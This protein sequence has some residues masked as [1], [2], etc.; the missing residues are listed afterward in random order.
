MQPILWTVLLGLAAGRS[1]TLPRS[2]SNASCRAIPGDASWPSLDKWYALNETVHGRL[3]AT[4]PLPRVCHSEP[5]GNYNA[6]VC[7]ALKTTWLDDTTFLDHPAEV[8]NPYVQNYTCVPFTPASQPCIL[9]NY[10]SYSINVT[11]AD[12]VIAG[13]AFARENNI[14]LVIKNTG[15]DFMGKSTGTGALSLWTHNLNTTDILP[16]YS[17]ANYTGPAARLGAGVISGQVY[18]I[19][20]AAGYRILG[21]TCPTVGLAGGYTSGGG[22]SLLNGAYGMGADAVLEWEVISAQGEHLVVT[23]YNNADLYW[24]LS[25]GGPGTF[26]VVLSMTTKIFVDGPIGSGLLFFN[27]SA[28]NP[29][30]Y[31]SAISDLWQFLPQFVD[32][33]PNTW[34]FA[35]TATGFEAYAITVPDKNGT[36]VQDLLK[37]FLTRLTQRDIPY[38]FTPTTSPSYHDYF[39]SR[40]GPGIA[41]AGPATVQ[42][43]SRLIPRAGVQSIMQNQAIVAALRAVVET[44]PGLSLGCHALNVKDI[45][46]PD[47]AVLPAW[48]DA[49]A[50]C[51]IVSYWDWNVSPQQMQARKAQLVDTLIPGL[52]RA[53][54]GAG[55]YLN[56]ID[57]QWQGN[58]EVELYG[59]NYPRLLEVKEKYDPAHVFYAKTAVGS[60]A[61]EVDSKGRLCRV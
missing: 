14:R 30:P 42:L 49:I 43:T 48:R 58:W 61:W 27:I 47:N 35:L 2:A 5:F 38:S 46:H 32:A 57:A 1:V 54:P 29:E 6:D 59:R 25:G 9:G 56:E 34:D 23:P 50:T 55:T 8:M 19:L 22:H 44:D 16:S 60:A 40:F 26:A 21:G 41:G 13:V 39:A 17:S 15:H 4:T 53:T 3:I 52:E 36:Q 18:S 45:P 33:G 37:P 31:W 10:A 20:G 51:N 12:D 28:T 24:A 11:G 7:S